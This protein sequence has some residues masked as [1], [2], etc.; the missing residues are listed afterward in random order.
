MI[1][2]TINHLSRFFLLTIF[3]L[4]ASP[5]KSEAQKSIEQALVKH[6]D[7]HKDLAMALLEQVVNINSGT[8]NFDGVKKLAISFGKNLLHLASRPDGW[9]GQHSSARGISWLSTPEKGCVCCLSAIWIRCLRR[10]VLFNAFGSSTI[11]RLAAR[12]SAT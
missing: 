11:R 5:I 4:F 9:M 3:L 1:N 10:T 8:M 6:V 7:E 2:K 12:E